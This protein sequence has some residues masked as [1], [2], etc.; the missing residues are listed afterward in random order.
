[1][2]G[3]LE[4]DKVV[5]KASE[6]SYASAVADDIV[7]QLAAPVINGITCDAYAPGDLNVSLDVNES[8]IFQFDS[9]PISFLQ[10]MIKLVKNLFEIFGVAYF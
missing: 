4:N 9:A 10:Y 5:A 6:I 2:S 7:V 8:G 3:Q 1:M